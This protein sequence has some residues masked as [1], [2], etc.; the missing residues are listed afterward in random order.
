M[1]KLYDYYEGKT[2]IAVSDSWTEIK[3]AKREYIRDTDGECDLEI[4]D[5]FGEVC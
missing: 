5:E 1:Y 4:V 2:L 3:K